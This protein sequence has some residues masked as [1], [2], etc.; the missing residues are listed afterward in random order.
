MIDGLLATKFHNP[1]AVGYLTLRP[2]LD[3][4]LEESLLPGCRLVLV[5]APAGFGKSTLIS[6]WINQQSL[7]FSWLSLDSNDN[8]PRL[9]MSYLVGALQKIDP[10]LGENQ[11]RRIQTADS[12]DREAVYLDVMAA[13][14]NEI[15]TLPTPFFLVLDDCHLLKS[16]FLLRLLTFLIER[17]PPQIRL[18]LLS[19]EDLPIPLSRLRV[20]RQV[21]E[22][23]QS[24]LQFTPHEIGDFLR[25]GMGITQL[26]GEDIV[27][28]EQ[29]TEGWIAGLQLAALSLKYS[30]D[31]SKFIRSFTGSDRYI[32]DYLMDEVFSYQPVA[33]QTFLLSTSILDRFCASLCGI[34]LHQYENQYDPSDSD[35]RAM[36]DQVERSSLFLIPLDTQRQWYR[37]HHLFADLLQHA[38]VEAAPQKINSL[39]L[40]ASRWFETNGYIDEAVKHGFRAR[41]WDYV[42]ELVERHAWNRIL[43]SQVATVSEWCRGFPEPVI[44]RRPALCIFHGWA[45]II[46][47]KKEDF[48]AAQVRIE[49]AEAC[50]SQIDPLATISLIVGA[51][52][53][54]LKRWV[55]GQI[56]LLRSFIL[57]AV[58]RKEINP[59]LFNGLSRRS[60]EELPPE[61]TTGLSVGLLNICYTSEALSDAE[62]ADKKFEQVVGVATRGGNY[63]GAVV[64]EY[65]RAHG[66]FIRG[67][68]RETLAF[69]AHKKKIYE[70]YFDNPLQELP[71]IALLDQAAGCALLELNE[72]AEAERLLRSGLA[73]GQYMPREELPGYLALARICAAKG[74]QPGIEETLRRLDMRWPD[75]RY[76]TEAIRLLAAFRFNPENTEIRKTASRWAEANPPEIGP[77]IVI[78]GFSVIWFDEADYAVYTAWIQI[79]ILLGQAHQALEVIQPMLEVAQDHGLNH[80]LIELDLL[81]AQAHYTLGQRERAWKPLRSALILAN[82]EGYLRL[83]DQGPILVRLMIEAA[84]I[85]MSPQYIQQNLASIYPESSHTPI[86]QDLQPPQST[87]HFKYDP[88]GLVE[89]LSSREVEILNL[90]ASGLNNAEIAARLYLS[91]NTL[92]AHT[93]NIYGKLGVHSRVQA[94]NKARVFKLI[95]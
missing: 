25:T 24:D 55:T 54:N 56:T 84:Q 19:R 44:A 9:F 58:P 80:R 32:L 14:V 34:M 57:M 4:R 64:A 53:V 22:I 68:L 42:T 37:Y 31:P 11:V 50:L 12:A 13:L 90:M 74:D 63:F 93:Q 21:I 67:R 27:A 52:P 15:S 6:S 94:L 65:H 26:T 89:P 7:P 95:E 1:L 48:P 77:G 91:P 18:V 60:L 59:D 46:A 30:P 40:A 66:L 45:L 10:T 82:Q 71:A 39:H 3:S 29:R 69:C 23:R 72:L 62:D 43:H 16:P 38:L 79:Q 35:A 61:D 92:K 81:Q 86:P 17:Q 76:C 36:L 28:L 70:N 75:I 88:D 78:P 5:N 8:E 33:I 41:D 2:R 47:F 87:R 49:Q 51:P 73:V 85:G 20:R 83:L